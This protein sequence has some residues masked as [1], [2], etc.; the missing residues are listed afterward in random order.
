M[1]DRVKSQ[2]CNILQFI[3]ITGKLKDT[4]RTGWVENG[5]CE[6]ESVADHMYRMAVMTMLITNKEGLNKERCMKLAI[7]HDLA[8]A[9]VGDVS[10]SQGISD[11]EKHRQEKDAITKM[12]SLLPKEIGLEIC[13]LYE[14]YEA[15][16]TNEAK[17]VK[18]LDMFD[19]IAQA[20]EYEKKEQRKGDLQ[21]FFNSTAGKFQHPEVKEWVQELYKEREGDDAIS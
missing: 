16:Q 14:E 17:F 1:D 2:T 21:T 18:D 8:E 4:Q 6:P 9:I 13:Q 12:T 10:P 19:M 11:E 15:R 3:H 5:V 7:V 20:H